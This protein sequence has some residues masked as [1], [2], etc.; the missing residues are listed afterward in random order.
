MTRTLRKLHAWIGFYATLALLF[1]SLTGFLLNH[2]AVLEIPALQKSETRLVLP[3]EHA[4]ADSEAMHRWLVQVLAM[5]AERIRVSH[6]EGRT[7]PWRGGEARIPERWTARADLPQR[8][9]E[10]EYWV[11][12]RRIEIK[13]GEPNLWLHLARYHMG[14]GVGV[15]WILFADS[16]ALV[17]ALMS[18]SG[19]FLWTR[20]HGR[21]L[22]ACGLIVGGITAA[23]VAVTLSI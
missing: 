19:L 17:L 7:V 20:L 23:G 11:G 14:I 22:L 2:R 8:Y 13:Q 12:E 16:I 9:A 5:P 10:A 3:L 4:F 18:V 1:F 15:G 6:S 21:R